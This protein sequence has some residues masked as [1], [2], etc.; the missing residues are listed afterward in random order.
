MAVPFTPYSTVVPLMGALPSW[1]TAQDA[2]RLESYRLYDQMYWSVPE[3]FKLTW[4]GG[5]D[6]PIYVP[7]AK[8]I[9]EACNR[10]LAVGFDYTLQGA[11][12]GGGDA[13]KAAARLALDTLFRRERFYSKFSTAK[14]YGLIRGDAILH[15]KA[16]PA[17]PA[18]RRISIMEVDPGS[19]FPIY[20]DQ[21]PDKLVG[22]HLVD[23]WVPDPLK[24]QEVV[25]RRQTYRK[26]VAG[27]G[28]NA[29][30]TS[31]LT[32]W[33]LGGWDDRLGSGQKLKKMP[34]G[35]PVFALPP[36][37]TSFPVYLWRNQLE[38][39]NPYGSSEL[40]GLE[41]ISGAVNQAISDQELA[42]ALAGLGTYATNSASP[43]DENGDE[44]DWVIAPAS[45]VELKGTKADVFF[46]RV[47]GIKS[48]TPSIDHLNWLWARI[49]ESSATPD[50]AT[51]VVDVAVAQSGIALILQM[52]PILAKNA[53]K[54]DEILGTADHL[55]YDL[56]NGWLPAYEG[57]AFDGVDAV[58]TVGDPMPVDR[59]AV[60]GEIVALLSTVP[61]VISTETAR[62]ILRDK[63][64]YEFSDTEAVA[65]INE[66]AD[67]A[68]ARDPFA[69]R[70]RQEQ[71]AAI[72][73][74][75]EG[76]ASA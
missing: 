49:K 74:G 42:L 15:L 10:Y 28:A 59:S 63:L 61:P 67:L 43:V 8:I 31:E 2:I 71:E 66:A 56:L 26:E 69:E 25:I 36:Q 19:Y 34:G 45:V 12:G 18:G 37:I 72:Q 35:T 7:S 70:L 1:L 14:R 23:Q 11:P 51:G 22:V 75:D 17:K 52:G 46:E 54:E 4:R 32:Y 5:E 65:V 33:E 13:T 73:A 60:I 30:I 6:N 3:T 68:V 53:E 47:D 24:P 64:G 62:A 38:P 20:E 50:I 55:F 41:R 16:D 48:V 58:P 29:T 76:Q 27:V 39:L 9:I 21:D 57:L 44:T 40:R